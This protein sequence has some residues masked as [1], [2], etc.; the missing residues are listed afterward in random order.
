MTQQIIP[1]KSPQLQ[2]SKWLREY[3]EIRNETLYGE[4]KI[5]NVHF[6]PP[7]HWM[8]RVVSV[9]R[10]GDFSRNVIKGSFQPYVSIVGAVEDLIFWTWFDLV[11]P[12]R[13]DNYRPKSLPPKLALT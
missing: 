13:R 11:N 12:N 8:A 10:A 5:E 9:Q 2:Q 7:D 6:V 1:T 3:C 4:Y